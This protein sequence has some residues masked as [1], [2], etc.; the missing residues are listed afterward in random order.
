MTFPD[1]L[2]IG[3]AKSGTVSLYHYLGQHPQIFMCP[4]NEP[5]FFALDGF[6]VDNHFK[7][8]GDRAAVDSHC[9]QDLAAYKA[10][11]EKA[12]PGQRLG[13]SSPLYLYSAHAAERIRYYVPHVRLIAVL[14][15]PTSRAHANFRHYR[16]AGIE[17]ITRFEQALAA[18]EARRAQRWG[19]WPF[20]SYRD[21]GNYA[22]QLQRYYAL[23]DRDQIMVCLYDELR[24]DAVALLQRMYA[25]IGVD[26]QFVPDT[27]VQHNVGSRPRARFLHR[28]MTQSNPF[29]TTIK[30][31]LPD[32][33]RLWLREWLGRLNEERLAL[34]PML[35]RQLNRDYAPGMQRL[36]ALIEQD[37]TPWFDTA[38]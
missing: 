33:P 35:R 28:L 11:F 6:D 38:R 20:W 24:D 5:N 22:E 18:E 26:S 15:Q 36:Q 1:F 34:D 17:P 9:V 8:P 7:G 12:R 13:E 37:L 30:R 14:R 4:V 27:S 25:F 21:V 31:A 3:A 23:F 19:P 32:R 10:L 2:I 29:K 16:I